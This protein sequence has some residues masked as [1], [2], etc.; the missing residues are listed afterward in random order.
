MTDEQLL[1]GARSG[2]ETAFL[3]LYERHRD[4][5]VRF[6]HRLLGAAE[7]A[8][9]VT[10]D[11]FLAIVSSAGNFDA[12]KGTLR[13]YMFG[14]V[15]NLA[16]KRLR[17]DEREDALEN[18]SELPAAAGGPLDAL[19]D[20]E[21]SA[22]VARAVAELPFLQREVLVLVEFE[23]LSLLEISQIV[24]A[25]VGVLKSRLH[26]ARERLRKR[27]APLFH[28]PLAERSSRE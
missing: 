14:T 10:H 11:C 4:P 28:Q 9:D 17:V 1:A 3:L 7:A 19:L 26:R 2:D 24:A 22:L 21:V 13:S 6:A 23:E 27:L 18:A 5:V 12:N 25:D 15:R 20:K 8:E 16:F